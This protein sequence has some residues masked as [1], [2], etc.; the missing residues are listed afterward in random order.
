M[1]GRVE[2]YVSITKTL[3]DSWNR[4]CR[5]SDENANSERHERAR[6]V[7]AAQFEA[8]QR[9]ADVNKYWRNQ[10]A[11]LSNEI[12]E[13]ERRQNSAFQAALSRQHKDIN[14]QINN[15]R[16]EIINTR[17]ELTRMIQNVQNNIEIQ[18][19]NENEHARYFIMQAEAYVREIG[20]Y[21]LDIFR[22][23]RLESI[24]SRIKRALYDISMGFGQAAIINAQTAFDES[25]DL[26]SNIIF[27]EIEWQMHYMELSR[28]TAELESRIN[29]ERIR[30]WEIG[31]KYVEARIDYW[32]NGRLEKMAERLQEIKQMMTD[33]T[34][35]ISGDLVK[36]ADEVDTMSNELGDSIIP[37]AKEC[38]FLAAHRVDRLNE[39]AARMRNIGWLLKDD[40]CGF[41]KNHQN[42]E[43]RFKMI[44][45]SNGS[46]AVFVL[47]P[48]ITQ[49][50]N[51]CIRF[52]YDIF[53]D[54]IINLEY[55]EAVRAAV[56]E[57]IG[58]GTNLNCARGYENRLSDR[59]EV[60]NVRQILSK[61]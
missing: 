23:S 54:K 1:S 20:A 47:A 42:N 11:G 59:I 61:E 56:Q 6:L 28:R 2:E 43:L 30:E 36:L 14:Q 8:N 22:K 4:Q 10:I 51:R 31:G 9:I 60:R 38:M 17:T 34:D 55:L 16:Q 46:E 58:R 50:G 25:V 37:Q 48:V 15:I 27:A 7:A 29:A 57:A 35:S 52:E 53:N 12:H 40:E 39:I 49:N 13:I 5:E 18:Q 24:R 45:P 33:M 44:N 41:L 32:T 21:R 26:R 19:L 3:R